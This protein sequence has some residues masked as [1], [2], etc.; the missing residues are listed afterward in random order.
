MQLAL[1]PKALVQVP[2]VNRE[3]KKGLTHQPV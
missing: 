2:G 1:T 3:N